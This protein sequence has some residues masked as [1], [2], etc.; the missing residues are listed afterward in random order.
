M[1]KGINMPAIEKK[2]TTIKGFRAGNVS[3]NVKSHSND[4]FVIKKVEEATETLKRV[5]LPDKQEK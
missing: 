4:P 2:A 5:G 3:S 1:M